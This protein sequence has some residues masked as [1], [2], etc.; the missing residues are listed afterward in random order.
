MG[1]CGSTESVLSLEDGWCEPFVYQIVVELLHTVVSVF[2][3]PSV[4]NNL[5]DPLV[6][7]KGHSAPLLRCCDEVLERLIGVWF[8]CTVEPPVKGQP[9]L[10]GVRAHGRY[11]MGGLFGNDKHGQRVET[12]MN[13]G[14]VVLLGTPVQRSTPFGSPV[15]AEVPN[16]RYCP[17]TKM[18]RVREGVI[19]GMIVRGG[20]DDRAV[21]VAARELCHERFGLFRVEHGDR[22]VH[23]ACKVFRVINV[24]VVKVEPVAQVVLMQR[25]LGVVDLIVHLLGHGF[26]E[27][28]VDYDKLPA[29]QVVRQVG[30]VVWV[31]HDVLRKIVLDASARRERKVLRGTGRFCQ[32]QRRQHHGA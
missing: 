25:V 29:L 32:C 1:L 4:V 8:P 27:G 17:L 5:L 10:C 14:M 3:Q 20:G 21:T 16:E 2:V 31:I 13:I 7:I 30:Q 23:K 18:V 28:V 15:L 11:E 6:L 26:G 24:V 19:P 22:V 9:L 12:G